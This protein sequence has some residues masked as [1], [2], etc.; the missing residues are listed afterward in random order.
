MV[1]IARRHKDRELSNRGIQPR[2][3]NDRGCDVRGLLHC[4]QHRYKS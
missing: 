1:R 2:V 4:G 3:L